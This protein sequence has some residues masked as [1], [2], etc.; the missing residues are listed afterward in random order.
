VAEP[1]HNIHVLGVADPVSAGTHLVAFLAMLVGM[2]A[3]VR[4]TAA[5]PYERVLVI[6]YSITTL[7]Q[8]AAST[9]YHTSEHDPFLRHVDHATIYL[10]I[11]GTFTALAGSQL[12]GWL[13]A[14]VLGSIWAFC[15]AGIVV[16]LFF[17]NYFKES[18]DTGFYLGAG[19]FG[20]VPTFV[21]WRRGERGTTA[22]IMTGALFYTAGALCE[23]FAWPHLI[24]KIFNFHEVFHL[25]V[26][27]A[28]TAFY[29]AVWR[30]V[31]VRLNDRVVLTRVSRT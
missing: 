8:Y 22:W 16:K 25:C 31:D 24:P 21:I 15:L 13:R 30:S 18:V 19:W 9:I 3:L 4:R 23:L 11:A 2:K 12:R 6:V 10:L 26:M 17:F 20:A 5:R 7:M 27:A 14:A 28:G 1:Q 29:I